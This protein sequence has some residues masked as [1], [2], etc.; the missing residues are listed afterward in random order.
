MFVAKA[1]VF[2]GRFPITYAIKTS[3]LFENEG[4][5]IQRNWLEILNAI[6]ENG[7]WSEFIKVCQPVIESSNN[8]LV[9]NKEQRQQMPVLKT[10][11][12]QM[13]MIMWMIGTK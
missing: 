2:I 13:M 4:I 7:E 3:E 9:V 10:I 1:T 11:K 6:N 5:E 8:L 12:I